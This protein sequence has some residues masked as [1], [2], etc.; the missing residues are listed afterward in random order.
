MNLHW[1][2]EVVHQ[3]SYT[4][5][6]LPTQALVY[7]QQIKVTNTLVFVSVCV[8]CV[9]CN[10]SGSKSLVYNAR[11]ISLYKHLQKARLFTS[12]Q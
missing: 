4:T 11:W 12:T 10:K 7:Q 8:C 2:T 1:E 9:R 3:I 5:A 6:T